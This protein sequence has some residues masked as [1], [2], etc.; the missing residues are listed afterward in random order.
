[1]W[2]WTGK[3]VPWGQKK[4]GGRCHSQ[5]GQGLHLC[6]QREERVS[7]LAVVPAAD[8][9]CPGGEADKRL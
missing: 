6:I 1:M 8:S 2:V 4:P 3:P 9:S 5:R 7:G